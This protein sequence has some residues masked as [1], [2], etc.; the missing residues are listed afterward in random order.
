M[1]RVMDEK[2]DKNRWDDYNMVLQCTNRDFYNRIENLF[3]PGMTWYNYGDGKE[4]WTVEYIIPLKYHTIYES[5]FH[6]QTNEGPIFITIEDMCMCVNIRP[7]WNK[8]LIDKNNS[9]ATYDKIIHKCY[10][11]INFKKAKQLESKNSSSSSLDTI[12]ENNFKNNVSC[13]TR[14]K[15]AE[16]KKQ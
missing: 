6:F 3:E 2:N 12:V 9:I 15:S 13:N 10:E 1:F 11:I 8:C 16:Y 4:D 14:K 7:V 5:L